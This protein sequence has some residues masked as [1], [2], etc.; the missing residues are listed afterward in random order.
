[1][2]SRTAPRERVS[3]RSFLGLLIFLC[4]SPPRVINALHTVHST[5]TDRMLYRDIRRYFLLFLRLWRN[6]WRNMWADCGPSIK[7]FARAIPGVLWRAVKASPLLA[8]AL[9]PGTYYAIKHIPDGVRWV[10]EK[11][12]LVCHWWELNWPDIREEIKFVLWCIWELLQ[13]AAWFIIDGLVDLGNFMTGEFAKLGKEWDEFAKDIN[14]DNI[15]YV[16]GR[17]LNIFKIWEPL[18]LFFVVANRYYYYPKKPIPA[19]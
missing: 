1:M 12:P 2:P 14:W 18:P 9:L 13:D 8:L 4:K 19:G 11:W 15:L 17:V 5:L 10:Q 16:S 6:F 3:L 7:A